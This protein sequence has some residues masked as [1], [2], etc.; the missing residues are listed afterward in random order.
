MRRESNFILVIAKFSL[1]AAAV[2]MAG[3]S[4]RRAAPPW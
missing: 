3:D 1:P 2:R 4:M